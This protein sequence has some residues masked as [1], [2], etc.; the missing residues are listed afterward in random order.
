MNAN[1]SPQFDPRAWLVWGLAASL[2]ALTGR[3]PFM[4]L[5]TLL[6]VLIV[7]VA[8][9]R[10][11]EGGPSMAGLIK[12]AA[13]F[14]AIGV[15]FNVLTV[16]SGD[17]VLTTIPKSLPLIG[18]DVT[19]NAV[20][21]GVLGGV[22]VLSLVITGL[23][24]TANLDWA[25]MMRLLPDSL[26]SL[27]VAGSIAFTF[28][29]QTIASFR[30][31]REARLI[32]GAPLRTPRDYA[33]L[34]APMLASG[35]DRAV[36]LS[37]LL[38]TRGLGGSSMPAVRSRGRSLAMAFGLSALCASAYLFAVGKLIEAGGVLLVAMLTATYAVHAAPEVSVRRTRFRAPQ[39]TAGDSIVAGGAAISVLG[40]VAT[41]L[42]NPDAIRYEPYP[43]LD[44]PVAGLA[45]ILA[46][47]GLLAPAYVAGTPS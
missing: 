22:A 20:V 28:F 4:L 31:L 47:L 11:T 23:T 34:A 36:T 2:P 43:T 13:V 33:M 37:E 45:L 46:L 8:V 7:R 16:H 12:L 14:V 25:T 30:E 24:V 21:F 27:G 38:E 35:L 39:W 6:C 9:G 18:G 40:V 3:N 41:L 19:L 15:V 32:R 5:V 42:W 26:V 17:R 29:P 10:S 44:A 1:A